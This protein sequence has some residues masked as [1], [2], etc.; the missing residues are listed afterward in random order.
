MPALEIQMLS[1]VI[2]RG[3]VGVSWC[4]HDIFKWVMCRQ[5]VRT[6]LLI[7]PGSGERQTVVGGE[8]YR[9]DGKA[10]KSST[11]AA[12]TRIDRSNYCLRKRLGLAEA[13]SLLARPGLYAY[14]PNANLSSRIRLKRFMPVSQCFLTA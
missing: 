1:R 13:S 14:E 8:K 11:N 10:R 12:R 3:V 9:E 2:R 4:A 5:A 7:R 6:F